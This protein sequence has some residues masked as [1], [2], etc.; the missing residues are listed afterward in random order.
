M[1]KTILPALDGISTVRAIVEHV[2]P[3]A[4]LAHLE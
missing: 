1:Y 3:L 2:K 4:K